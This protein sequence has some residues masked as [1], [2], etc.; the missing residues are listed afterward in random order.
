V[1][2]NTTPRTWT[3]GEVVTAAYMN[4]EVRDALAGIQAAWTA[5]TPTV[6]ADG[7]TFTT[8]SASGRYNRTGKT[9]DFQVSIVMTTAGTATGAVRF[10]LPVT[11][12]SSAIAIGLGR[13]MTS[14]GAMLVVM[15]NQASASIASILTYSNTS[16]IGSGRTLALSGSYEAA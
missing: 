15:G 13:E 1:S 16:I 9:I 3:T 8:V 5:Y 4:T 7:G 14:T 10:T 2:L 12:H 6:T 11:A